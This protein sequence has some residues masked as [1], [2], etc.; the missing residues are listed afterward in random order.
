MAINYANCW[1]K[2]GDLTNAVG[3]ALSET[4]GFVSKMRGRMV[5]RSGRAC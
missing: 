2:Y 1:I 4:G 3:F 5:G